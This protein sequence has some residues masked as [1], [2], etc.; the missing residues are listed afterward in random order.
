MAKTFDYANFDRSAEIVANEV[1][2]VL[3]AYRLNER[4]Y[5]YVYSLTCK[6]VEKARNEVIGSDYLAVKLV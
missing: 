2:D 6:Q 1:I 5:N 3:N 4:Q